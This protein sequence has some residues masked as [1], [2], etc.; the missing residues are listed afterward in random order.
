MHIGDLRIPWDTDGTHPPL[1][2][3]PIA[4]YDNQRQRQAVGA[5][6]HAVPTALMTE[7]LPAI[8]IAT[9][10]NNRRTVGQQDMTRQHPGRM[11][12]A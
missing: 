5:Q 12:Q 7:Q 11:G 9:Q 6:L 3:N 10:A 8:L 4:Q 1:A 2:L